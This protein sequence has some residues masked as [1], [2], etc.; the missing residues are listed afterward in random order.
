MDP[1]AFLN[2]TVYHIVVWKSHYIQ[3][4]LSLPRKT[5]RLKHRDSGSLNLIVRQL[6]EEMPASHDNSPLT[7]QEPIKYKDLILRS[8]AV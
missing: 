5:A 1:F 8:F 6:L 4:H 3:E 2:T 7:D